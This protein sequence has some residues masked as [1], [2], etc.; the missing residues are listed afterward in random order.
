MT[1][2][3]WCV[4]FALVSGRCAMGFPPTDGRFKS[5][6]PGCFEKEERNE[7]ICADFWRPD[8]FCAGGACQMR[9]RQVRIRFRRASRVCP[10]RWQKAETVKLPRE[11]ALRFL[12]QAKESDEFEIIG[13]WGL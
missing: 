1:P 4:G 8:R 2:A 11:G 13:V 9:E 6:H 7:G 3:E 5:A 10:G 12:A